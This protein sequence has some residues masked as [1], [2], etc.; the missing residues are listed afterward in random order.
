MNGWK[1][2]TL[3]DICE[4]IDYGYTASASQIPTGPRFL[5]ITD[6]VNGHIRWEDV[7]Y[8]NIEEDIKHKYSLQSGDIV[9]ARTGAS[10]GTSIY[11]DN[12]PDSIFASYLVRLKIGRNANSR[13]VSYFLKSK[14]F[15]DYI[16]GV[17][18]DKSAQ[19]NASA[20]TM[21]QVKFTVPPLD[22][23]NKV[24]NILGSLD[25][26]IELNRRMNETLEA[27]AKAIFKSWFIDFDPVH[28]K[29]AG[30]K[31]VGMD[32]ATATLFPD[33][34]ED[35][36]LGEIPKG[37]KLG[38]LAEHVAIYGGG[39]PKTAIAEYW[40][41]DIPWFSVVDAPNPSDVFVIN[42]EKKI[43]K[44]GLNNSSTQLLSAG[45]TIITARGTVGELALTGVPMTMNQS[46]YGLRYK[47]DNLG[48][49]TYYLVENILAILKS[50]TH[51]SVFDTITRDTL[52]SVS[53]VL[54]PQQLINKYSNCVHT[55]MNRILNNLFEIGTLAE[56]RDLLLPK[57]ISGEIEVK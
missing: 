10:T 6:I 2:T 50:R 36:E 18:G 33:S 57:L 26:K 5:R 53:V 31:P 17:L 30:E 16:N 8:C 35:S 24:A 9:I 54:P 25:D 3:A 1:E 13:Y 21:T 38:S 46:C 34:F 28:A 37:W 45:T 48:Y 14:D 23:Q 43:T 7:P 56:I 39:T 44:S 40:N 41:G 49:Y 12:P 15:S 27:I 19:P 29:M 51:G 55:T 42:T 32:D 20:S 52:A 47:E 11:I 4:S 22:H